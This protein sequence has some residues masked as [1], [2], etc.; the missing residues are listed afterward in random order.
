M[1]A[2]SDTRATP[3]LLLLLLALA[4]LLAAGCGGGASAGGSKTR[5][6]ASATTHTTPA[7]PS[8]RFIAGAD[9]LCAQVDAPI[10]RVKAKNAS[11]REI[12]RVVPQHAA[13]ELAAVRALSRLTPPPALAA[14]WQQM[15]AYRRKLADELLLLVKAAKRADTAAVKALAASKL[16]A[17]KRLL[18]TAAQAGFKSCGKVG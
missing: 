1:Q 12:E 6:T 8:A 16:A 18:Q 7:D 5:A 4:G 11:A 15:L 3:S 9:R 2:P 17:H 14:R 10:N 13:V